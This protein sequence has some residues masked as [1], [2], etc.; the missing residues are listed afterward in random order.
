MPPKAPTSDIV[1]DFLKQ[2]KP[3]QRKNIKQADILI[4]YTQHLSQI[5]IR[6]K[7]IYKIVF[8]QVR[9]FASVYTLGT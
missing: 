7:K 9:W 5:Q 4:N 3:K 2:Q 1:Y 8:I 6:K